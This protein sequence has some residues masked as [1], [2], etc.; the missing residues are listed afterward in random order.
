MHIEGANGFGGRM[1]LLISRIKQMKVY[2]GN[3]DMARYGV[4]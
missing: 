2:R 3:E 4:L 1:D